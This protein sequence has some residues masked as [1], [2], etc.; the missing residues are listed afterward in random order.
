M[1]AIRIGIL[2]V[3][4][5]VAA[6]TRVDG[7]GSVIRA[8]ADGLGWPVAAHVV[9]PDTSD[10]IVAALISLADAGGCD[11]VL[12]TGG[13]G[14]TP[15]DVTPEATRAVL[16]RAAPGVAEAIRLRG[17]AQTHYSW[18]S[19]GLAG[20]RG[21]TLIVNLPGSESGVRDGLQVLEP[22]IPHAVQLMRAIDTGNHTNG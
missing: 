15:R 5:G 21:A 6:G 1:S 20:T 2:T 11:V 13:T 7:S 10:A 12:T 19:R 4:D 17:A 18:L 3:S 22:L 14:F 8:W 16:E 9:V